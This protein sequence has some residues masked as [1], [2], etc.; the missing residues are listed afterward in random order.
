[1]ITIWFCAPNPKYKRQLSKLGKYV[2]NNLK[3]FTLLSS[4]F[5]PYIRVSVY[6][7]MYMI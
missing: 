7:H 3:V 4:Q 1:M 6:V 5:L 2:F